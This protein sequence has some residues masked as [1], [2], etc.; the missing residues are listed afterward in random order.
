MLRPPVVFGPEARGS[1]RLLLRLAATG[2][3][4]PF[5]AID[6]RRSLIAT[7]NLAS[8]IA[9]LVMLRDNS[10]LPGTYLVSDDDILSLSQILRLLRSGMGMP[11]RLMS[12]PP[13]LVRGLLLL[14]GR[15][16]MAPSLL[17]DLAVDSRLFGRTFGWHPAVAATEALRQCGAAFRSSGA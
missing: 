13:A 5:G 4:L 16:G 2:L 8:A 1:W 6:N 14:A 9:H 11:D 12:V 15:S 3:P 7:D 17:D 10:F